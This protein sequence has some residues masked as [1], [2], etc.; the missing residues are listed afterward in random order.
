MKDYDLIAYLY[1]DVC[2]DPIGTKVSSGV[3]AIK[4]TTQTAS[5]YTYVSVRSR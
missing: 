4:E 2:S 5:I 3:Y 1:I